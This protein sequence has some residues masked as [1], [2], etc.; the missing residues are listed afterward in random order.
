MSKEMRN[1]KER[2]YQKY[3]TYCEV[4]GK[5]FK[6]T[7]LTGHHIVMRCKGGKITEGNILIACWHCHFDVINHLKYDSKEYWDLMR[8]SLEHRK[9]SSKKE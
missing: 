1:V 9:L 8:K 2:L 7:E 3:G 5:K 4:C 6:K